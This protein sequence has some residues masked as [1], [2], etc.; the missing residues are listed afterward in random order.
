MPPEDEDFKG[1]V[2]ND[3]DKAMLLDLFNDV[4][5]FAVIQK[6]KCHFLLLLALLDVLFF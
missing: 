2:M 3:E 6:G 5:K 1:E 4:P